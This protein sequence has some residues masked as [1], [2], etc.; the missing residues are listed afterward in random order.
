MRRK[1][2][3]AWM[4]CSEILYSYMGIFDLTS[5][6]GNQM[7]FAQEERGPKGLNFNKNIAFCPLLP[8]KCF[9][10]GW[11][12][13]Q[14]F[15]L[16]FGFFIPFLFLSFSFFYQF[17]K[18]IIIMKSEKEHNFIGL[19]LLS[20]FSIGC[21]GSGQMFLPIFY[22]KVLG[23]GND[24]IGFIFSISKCERCHEIKTIALTFIH[25]S[26]LCILYCVPLLDILD[27]QDWKIQRNHD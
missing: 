26:P 24:K 18:K 1:F 8:F 21:I 22:K 14:S 5:I 19:K 23:L 3:M 9:K 10:I 13:K 2:K 15:Y 20:A 16:N 27:R 6:K 12:H 17:A 25:I 11:R 4:E 7:T